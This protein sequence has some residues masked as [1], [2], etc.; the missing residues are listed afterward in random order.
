[1]GVSCE[2][3]IIGGV[4]LI[5]IVTWFLL[6]THRTHGSGIEMLSDNDLHCQAHCSSDRHIP[7]SACGKPGPTS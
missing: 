5:S 4:L 7:T 2:S 1:M 6:S 3:N